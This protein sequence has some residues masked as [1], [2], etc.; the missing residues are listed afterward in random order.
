MER[1]HAQ[2]VRVQSIEKIFAKPSTF[3]RVREIYVCRGNHANVEWRFMPGAEALDGSLLQHTQ[4]LHLHVRRELADLIEKYRA[5]TGP[6]KRS[7]L[8]ANGARKGAANVS[9]E[10]V[11]GK[12]R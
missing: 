1:R 5:A 12:T 11:F 2:F 8:I 9:E 6:L 7:W 10:L 3:A 4:Q